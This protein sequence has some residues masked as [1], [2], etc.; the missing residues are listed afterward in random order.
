MGGLTGDPI[1]DFGGGGGGGFPGGGG[2]S[3]GGFPGGGLGD[4]AGGSSDMSPGGGGMPQVSDYVPQ[5]SGGGGTGSGGGGG[6]T[7]PSATTGPSVQQSQAQS[8]PGATPTSPGGTQSGPPQHFS[9]DDIVKALGMGGDQSSLRSVSQQNN[10]SVM[11]S[12]GP[13]TAPVQTEGRDPNLPWNPGTATEGPSSTAA[14]HNRDPN[15]PWNPQ[16][17]P[18]YATPGGAGGGPMA[19]TGTMPQPNRRVAE[20]GPTG[21]GSSPQAGQVPQVPQSPEGG[22]AGPGGPTQALPLPS[23]TATGPETGT[24]PQA[25]HLSSPLAAQGDPRDPKTADVPLPTADPRTAGATPPATAPSGGQQQQAGGRQQQPPFGEGFNPIRAIVD[26]LTGN[27]GD[28]NKMIQEMQQASGLGPPGSQYA[29]QPQQAQAPQ[30]QGQDPGLIQPKRGETPEQEQQ[31]QQQQRA[32]DVGTPGTYVIGDDGKPM[33]VKADAQGNPQ[34]DSQGK[35]IPADAGAGAAHPPQPLPAGQ[36]RP[37][38]SIPSGPLVAGN[39]PGQIQRVG[40]GRLGPPSQPSVNRSQFQQQLNEQT[41]A[42]MAHM[43]NG[44]VG[45]GAPIQAKIVQLETLFNRA[46]IRNDTLDSA[47]KSVTEGGPHGRAGPYYAGVRAP[48][49]G[50]YGPGSR[51]SAAEVEAFKRDVLGPVMGG[52]NLS[53]VGHGPMTGNASANVAANQFGRGTFGYKLRGGDTYFSEDRTLGRLPT[54]GPTSRPVQ[55]GFTPAPPNMS[56][57]PPPNN[58]MASLYDGLGFV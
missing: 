56:G 1:S 50:T 28:L 15:L 58:N 4:L 14:D 18:A 20:A 35:P 2:D 51:P 22:Y 27:F 38:G 10:T 46:Q 5:S 21:P 42:K 55:G 25:T 36:D 57:M 29:P 44:E 3:G 40:N 8:T 45:K 54:M 12:E 16:P 32:Q 52:S 31:R 9:I 47:L 43:V 41:I 17:Q 7:D 13:G 26:M 6:A 37:P 11:G 24:P 39:A 48:G 33:R 53:D 49:G 30:K 23:E 34:Y 19:G